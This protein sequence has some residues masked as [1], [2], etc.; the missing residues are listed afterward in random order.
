MQA[1]PFGFDVMLIFLG[2]LGPRKQGCGHR[3]QAQGAPEGVSSEQEWG[4]LQ[5]ECDCRETE[6]A[7]AVRLQKSCRHSQTRDE[8]SVL[9]ARTEGGRWGSRT[10]HRT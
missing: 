10:S 8:W 6:A 9:G 1:R 3:A 7:G 2:L 5:V 4:R